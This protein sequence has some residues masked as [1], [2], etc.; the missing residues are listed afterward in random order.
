MLQWG[1]DLAIAEMPIFLRA[2]L[3]MGPLQ[4]GR[5][6]AIA[7]IQIERLVLIDIGVASMGPRP[8]DRGNAFS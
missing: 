1:R 3:T 2:S 4:W 5:D 6:L 8:F 7:E